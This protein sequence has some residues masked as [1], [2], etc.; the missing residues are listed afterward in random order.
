MPDT[1][2]RRRTP[3]DI[4]LVKGV[5]A[6]KGKGVA[7]PD[8]PKPAPGVPPMPDG[9]RADPVQTA[10]WTELVYLTTLPG[11][12]VL[13]IADGPMLEL[14]CRA[15]SFMLAATDAGHWNRAEKHERA[16]E[17]RLCHFGLSPAVRGKVERVQE[18]KPANKAARHFGA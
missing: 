2:G 9:V 13:T 8:E 18:P 14:A 11:A 12:Y 6:G 10:K 7:S 1:R 3:A 4:R 17:R 15:W 16:Y 5:K